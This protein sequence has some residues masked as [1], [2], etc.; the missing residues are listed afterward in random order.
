MRSSGESEGIFELAGGF[1][2]FVLD[3]EPVGQTEHGLRSPLVA[4][5]EIRRRAHFL[6]LPWDLLGRTAIGSASHLGAGRSQCL[7]FGMDEDIAS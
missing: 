1:D 2:D 7:V 5:M 3:L 6:N 4:S